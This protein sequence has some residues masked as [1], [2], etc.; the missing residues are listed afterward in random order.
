MPV[1]YPLILA[2]LY[3]AGMAAFS[4]AFLVDWIRRFERIRGYWPH[5]VVAG[6]VL[7][8]LNLAAI[9]LV[10]IDRSTTTVIHVAFLPALFVRAAGFVMLGMYYCARIGCRS[11][12]L[13][14]REAPVPQAPLP[15]IAPLPPVDSAGPRIGSI[16]P[17]LSAELAAILAEPTPQADCPATTVATDGCPAVHS[18]WDHARDILIVVAASAVY[19]TVLFLLTEP[20]VTETVKRIFGARGDITNVDTFTALT[21]VVVLAYAFAEEIFFRLGIQNFLAHYLGWQGRRY[22]AAIAMTSL[23]WTLGHAGVLDPNWVKLVQVYPMG[24]ALGWLFR[25]HGVEACILAHGLFNIVMTGLS[26][27]LLT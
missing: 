24:L 8:G 4:L 16:E 11:F 20:H 26:P 23:L 12:F 10:P 22:W 21:V 9:I 1:E 2:L 3:L 14:P 17:D 5:A 25:R 19:S 27:F 18:L 7:V 13:L 6:A 15:Q